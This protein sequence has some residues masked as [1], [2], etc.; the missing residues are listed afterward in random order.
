MTRLFRWL[1]APAP[2][3]LDP[4]T[5]PIPL[6]GLRRVEHHGTMVL[7]VWA[8]EDGAESDRLVTPSHAICLG[9]RLIAQGQAA[10]KVCDELERWDAATTKHA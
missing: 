10:A 5:R 1:R 4:P 8:G 9:E 2:A 3:P 6:A 7:L